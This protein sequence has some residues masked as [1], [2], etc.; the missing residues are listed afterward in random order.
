MCRRR[1]FLR[2]PAR[3]ERE[4][5]RSL[6]RPGSKTPSFHLDISTLRSSRELTAQPHI[7]PRCICVVSFPP[8]S[9]SLP[10]RPSPH[11]V[12]L[13]FIILRRRRTH[14]CH[15]FSRKT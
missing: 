12:V 10:N 3:R 11:H 1:Q 5:P 8:P 7:L 4:C 15:R 14:S 13:Q 2:Y 6:N 9:P